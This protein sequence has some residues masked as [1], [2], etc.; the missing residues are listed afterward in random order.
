M[1]AAPD[2]RIN[3]TRADLRAR[4]RVRKL[5]PDRAELNRMFPGAERI[6]T[7]KRTGKSEWVVDVKTHD[8]NGEMTRDGKK[9]DSAMRGYMKAKTE[10]GRALT[11]LLP[12]PVAV[13]DG[14]GVRRYIQPHLADEAARKHGWSSGDRPGGNRVER[15]PGGM[16]FRLLHGKWEP[17]GVTCL[18]TPHVGRSVKPRGLQYDPDGHPWRKVEGRWRRVG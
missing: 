11:G 12:T 8:S 18:S 16:L 5:A 4:Q 17:L 14:D 6:E 10:Q 7:D 9:L 3:L 13:K 15:G 2:L 1:S